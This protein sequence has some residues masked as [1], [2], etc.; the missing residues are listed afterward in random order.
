VNTLLIGNP[1][2]A[3][4]L[5]A[6]PA[7]FAIHF[8]QERTRVLPSSTLFLL[9][10]V[11]PATPR[12]VV[13]RRLRSSWTLWLQVLAALLLAWVLCEPRWVHPGA[14]RRITLVVDDS[15][16]MGAFRS[17]V[18]QGLETV[19]RP[20]ARTPVYTEW[21]VLAA[22]RAHDPLYRGPSLDAALNA[23][24]A[25]EWVYPEGDL[26]R[27]LTSAV[28]SRGNVPGSVFWITDRQR[29]GLPAGV[30]TLAFGEPLP[31]CGWAGLRV[32]TAGGET[33]WEAIVRNWS[34]TAQKRSWAWSDPAGETT[35]QDLELLPGGLVTLR[36]TFPEGVSRGRL[37]LSGDVF[38]LDDSL[39]LLKPLPRPLRVGCVLEGGAPAE[40][41]RRVVET[42]PGGE[43]VKAGN[44]RV[45]V[46]SADAPAARRS[47]ALVLFAGRE[48]PPGA[49]VAVGEEH[50]LVAGQDW[51]GLLIGATGDLTPAAGDAV[52]VWRAGKPLVW[53]GS[54][55]GSP[56]LVFNFPFSKSNADRLPAMVLLLG[57]F[58]ARVQSLGDDFCRDNAV[59][60]EAI[61]VTSGNGWRLHPAQGA[62]IPLPARVA[63][64]APWQPGPFEVR[65]AQQ[66]VVY[67][68]AAQFVDPRESDFSAASW[69]TD[70]G[71]VGGQMNLQQSE[72]DS[73]NE[74]WIL[75]AGLAMLGAWWTSSGGMRAFVPRGAPHGEA[76]PSNTAAIGGRSQG[77]GREG[78]RDAI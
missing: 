7:I 9:G 49:G 53:L 37:S 38:A 63:L 22:S 43:F 19:L 30:Q 34:D 74:L 10:A 61:P 23:V 5:L 27:V 2:G 13:L 16:S 40:W 24:Q 6:A 47:V 59:V 42:V 57:R 3:W 36:G 21:T 8:L 44:V 25:G 77:S 75:L 58:L 28:L 51:Q 50:P 11:D 71:D 14:W 39:D 1:S 33:L 4:A 54:V 29:E 78:A 62:P 18:I 26:H 12:G 68:G 73:L 66:K 46:A 15:A 67:E 48:F 56:R 20:V 17:R 72:P 45:L 70:L 76:T 60:G 55:E 65:D 41:T 64:T 69:F 35:K 52:L 32:W 31:N